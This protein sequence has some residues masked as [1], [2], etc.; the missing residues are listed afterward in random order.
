MERFE[1]QVARR[2]KYGSNVALSCVLVI[3]LAAAVV[4]LLQRRAVRFDTTSERVYSLTPYT[5]AVLNGLS[6]RVRLVSLYPR[7]RSPEEADYFTPVADLL[8]EYARRTSR[9]TVDLIDPAREPSKLDALIAEVTA[10][11]GQELAPYRAFLDTIP[12]F[13]ERFKAWAEAESAKVEALPLDS[14]TDRQLGQTLL[15][16]RATVRGL[17][18]RLQDARDNIDRF[19]RGN[20]PDFR[21]AV[22]RVELELQVLE[23]LLARVTEDFR[24]LPPP[25]A[26][27]QPIADYA[28]AATD[29]FARWLEEV[30]QKLSA[31]RELGE[32]K[33]EALRQSIGRRT[34]LVMGEREMKVLSFDDVWPL[35]DDLRSFFLATSE[36]RPRRKFAGEQQVT[37]A[38]KALSEP[39]RRAVIFV[40]PGG[41]P[42]TQSLFRPAQFSLLARRL[43]E[44]NFDVLEKDL[45]GQFMMQARMQGIPISEATDEQLRDRRNIWLVF[46]LTPAF[47]PMGPSPLGGALQQHLVEGGSAVV[48]T[49]PE[50]DDLATVLREWGLAVRTDAIVVK[51]VPDA[52]GGPPSGDLIEQ[53]ERIPYVFTTN[54]AGDAPLARPV[55]GQ[56]MLLLAVSPV[57]FTPAEGLTAGSL[58]PI[59][60]TVRTW[61]ETSLE[62][63][64]DGKPPVFDPATDLENTD[65]QPL[66]GGAAVEKS[67]PEGSRRLVVIGSATTFSNAVMTLPDPELERRGLL[68][69][70]FPGNAEL[71]LN[72]VYWAAG[73]DGLIAISPAARDVPRIGPIPDG[74]LA[75]LRWGVVMVGLPLT[76][77]LAGVG[78]YWVRRERAA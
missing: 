73:M 27:P 60:R 78:V 12:P 64:F 4:A 3:A 57:V 56:S 22:D 6:E 7:E 11:Y 55:N 23:Q 52:A 40:R 35:P 31:A 72:A 53:A 15:V 1:S 39:Q 29:E 24:S 16:A 14:V 67:A 66:F 10:A 54:R 74:Q 8:Q 61:G 59:P 26:T 51:A 76:V 21:A 13:V 58:L 18:E 49:E 37:T 2:W 45:S 47:G 36:Q 71:L 20:L 34:L 44:A 77:V 70:R 32:L 25:P 5:L 50:R 68:V 75:F 65:S 19:L 63:V 41:V 28:A 46:G 9:I 33:L 30:R 38:I 62:E 17:P 48:L 43:R 69:P 42:L